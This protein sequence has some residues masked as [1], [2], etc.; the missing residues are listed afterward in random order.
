MA[1]LQLLHV[2]AAL[3]FSLAGV[4]VLAAPTPTFFVEGRVY[5]DTCRTGFETPA[6]VYIAGA[7]VRVECK[8]FLSNAVEHTAEGLTDASGTYRIEL[9]DDHE[10]QICEVVLVESPVAGCSEITGGRERARVLVAGNSGLSSNVRYANALGFLKDEPLPICGF[11]LR[12][13][14]LGDDE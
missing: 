6:T 4:V 14:A 1:R 12:Q 11:L 8:H 10:E 7:K 5:C 2:L 9:A 13:Y 3:C